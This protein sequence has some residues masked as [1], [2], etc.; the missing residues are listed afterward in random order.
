MT[1]LSRTSRRYRRNSGGGSRRIRRSR[2]SRRIRRS[3]GSRR[4][5]R[6]RSRGV[7]YLSPEIDCNFR[8]APPP[9]FE[10][11]TIIDELEK[12]NR[13]PKQQRLNA[14]RSAG[15]LFIS[16]DNITTTGTG[17]D[18]ERFIENYEEGMDM[19]VISYRFGV[20]A[21]RLTG[22]HSYL[23]DFSKDQIHQYYAIFMDPDYPKDGG[24]KF[25][26]NIP[27]ICTH[28]PTWKDYCSRDDF[29]A[30][31]AKAKDQCIRMTDENVWE[32]ATVI[33]PL[34]LDCA[35]ED[36]SLCPDDVAHLLLVVKKG[37][38]VFIYDNHIIAGKPRPWHHTITEFI[39][40]QLKE[41]E[42]IN[43]ITYSTPGCPLMPIRNMCR[44]DCILGIMGMTIPQ[45][46]A[47]MTL[48]DLVGHA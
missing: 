20:E 39:R 45:F 12:I 18:F 29:R 37:A 38:E 40:D 33:I 44:Y 43:V 26:A 17:K 6:R 47:I 21:A 32:N 27:P 7:S 13:L 9:T 2:G 23:Y 8:A 16:N 41:E 48:L 35:H 19:R 5:R 14:L 11:K 3:R 46:Q 22:N 36:G 34:G 15:L 25:Y 10:R 28:N 1:L 24:T 31:F 30:V 4:I 42:G